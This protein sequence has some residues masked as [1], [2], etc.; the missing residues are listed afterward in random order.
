MGRIISDREKRLIIAEEVLAQRRKELD[1]DIVDGMCGRH[2]T[3]QATIK[4][5][6]IQRAYELALKEYREAKSMLNAFTDEELEAM[7]N[8]NEDENLTDEQ[9]DILNNAKEWEI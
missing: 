5:R 4:S 1:K 6:E 3:P 2:T 9:K 7:I 8:P